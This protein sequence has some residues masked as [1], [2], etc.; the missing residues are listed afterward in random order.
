MKHCHNHLEAEA[1]ET[2]TEQKIQLLV[3]YS[4]KHGH[5]LIPKKKKQLKRTLPDHFNT[6]ISYKSSTLSTKFLRKHKTDF[7]HKH[8]AVYYGKR[9]KAGCKDDYERETKRRIVERIK[10]HNNKNNSS[11]IL[12]HAHE[13][14]HTHVWEKDFQISSNN[15]QSNVKPK[16][17]ESLVIKRLK[18]TLNLNEK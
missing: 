10:D 11:H 1:V 15:Y 5:Q 17:S 9:P 12:N 6:M 16:I 18:A 2:K 4:G 14:S 7:H 13:N 8:N 3:L